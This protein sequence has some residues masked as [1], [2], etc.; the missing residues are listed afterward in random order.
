MLIT[1]SANA[2]FILSFGARLLEGWG[3]PCA[4]NKSFVAW[5]KKGAKLVQADAVRTRT[6]SMADTVACHQARH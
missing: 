3:T 2:D 6:A 1:I 4:M 5:K